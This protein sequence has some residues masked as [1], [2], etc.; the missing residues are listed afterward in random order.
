MQPIKFGTDGWRGIIAEDYTLLNV[1]RAASAIANYVLKNEDSRRGVAVVNLQ[2]R[3]E[4]LT[5]PVVRPPLRRAAAAGGDRG[6]PTHGSTRA[7]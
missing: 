5:H 4:D 1:R 2:V 6:S 3:P 7:R